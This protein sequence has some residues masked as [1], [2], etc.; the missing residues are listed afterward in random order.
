MPDPADSRWG[1]PDRQRP[2]RVHPAT[3]LVR[4][5]G[6]VGRQLDRAVADHLT[7]NE[8]DMRAMSILLTRGA[9]T[10]SD[11]AA[12]LGLGIPSTSMA[13]DR[14]EHLGHVTRERDPADR[15]RVIVRASPGSTTRARDALMPMIREV[16]NLLDDLSDEDRTV[17]QRYLQGVTEA[18]QRRLEEIRSENEEQI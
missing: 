14:L 2:G 11:L 13:V 8:T 3:Y 15:R 16:D 18:M 7:V 12:A 9:M 10:V 17:V 5:I 6:A 4:E 1:D